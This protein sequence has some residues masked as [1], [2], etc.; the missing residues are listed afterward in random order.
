MQ[1]KRGH[2]VV[3]KMGVD[4]FF[5]DPRME[6]KERFQP[7]DE[8][9]VV[10]RT[11]NG[12]LRVRICRTGWVVRVRN[13][14]TRIEKPFQRKVSV[15]ERSQ[16]HGRATYAWW[17]PMHLETGTYTCAP[18]EV[19]T[20]SITELGWDKMMNALPAGSLPPLS[21]F[22]V[23]VWPKAPVVRTHQMY[24]SPH[25]NPPML[26][27]QIAFKQSNLCWEVDEKLL[28]GAKHKEELAWL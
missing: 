22:V 25:S 14:P 2:L 28:V 13:G 21:G 1:P 3:I 27:K 15:I 23:K 10:S 11:K 9:R 19:A 8:G 12:W 17:V 24:L 26:Q 16:G 6:A 5:S 20:P 4:T 7:G 18:M